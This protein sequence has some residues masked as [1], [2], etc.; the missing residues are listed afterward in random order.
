[1]IRPTLFDINAVEL[2]YHP[3][4]ISLNK[5]TGNCNV[6]YPKICVPKE[7]KDINI[8]A[9]NIITNKNE[10]KAKTGHISCVYKCKTYSAT[11]SSIVQQVIQIKNGIIK[12][13]NVK[14]KIT[15]S[16]KKIIVKILAQAFVRI[17]SI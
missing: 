12:H 4:M 17:V 1:M 16:T 13:A 2:K 15:V 9:F 6:L 7:T 11:C 8:K 14:V 10:A 5:C 3:F